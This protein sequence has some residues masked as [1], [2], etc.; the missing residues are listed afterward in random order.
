MPDIVLANVRFQL[1]LA[2]DLMRGVEQ[3]VVFMNPIVNGFPA[4]PVA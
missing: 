1:Y 4:C 3:T 2:S